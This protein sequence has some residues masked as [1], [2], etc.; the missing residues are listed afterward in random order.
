MMS[1]SPFPSRRFCGRCRPVGRGPWRGRRPYCG[2]RGWRRRRHK[3]RAHPDPCR[4]APA[5]G[6]FP[7]RTR[8][9]DRFR[10][11]AP[12]QRDG[13][14]DLAQVAGGARFAGQHAPQSL[15]HFFLPLGLAHVARGRLAARLAQQFFIVPGVL[16]RALRGVRRSEPAGRGRLYPKSGVGRF[17]RQHALAVLDHALVVLG[18]DGRLDQR[19]LDFVAA[20]NSDIWRDA[21]PARG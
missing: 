13:L 20:P 14:V 10:N 7:G 19:P 4:R 3:G 1:P 5:S 12:R 16:Q 17:A 2:Y 18:F 8:P 21:F 11:P 15:I 6:R 9:K